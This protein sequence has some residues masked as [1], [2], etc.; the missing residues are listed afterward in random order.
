MKIVLNKYL[1]KW[2]EIARIKNHFETNMTGV[3]AEYSLNDDGEIRVV[4]SG[5]INGE[6]NFITGIAKTTDKDDLL[7]VSFFPG[8]DLEY[9]IIAIRGDYE[10]AL[11]GGSNEN[12]LWILGRE[13]YIYREYLEQFITLATALGY[14]VDNLEITK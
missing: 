6:L 1:G 4:N 13:N 9:K 11:V 2:F 10:Y 12:Y 3:T 14:N 8:I 7:M 5:Y